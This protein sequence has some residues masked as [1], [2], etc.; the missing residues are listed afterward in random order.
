VKIRVF[1]K[2]KALLHGI[3]VFQ[4]YLLIGASRR[5]KTCWLYQ[6]HRFV[7][8]KNCAGFQAVL[9]ALH[10]NITVDRKLLTVSYHGSFG[11]TGLVARLARSSRCCSGGDCLDHFS[12]EG[13]ENY[14]NFFLRIP[15][16][17][18][19]CIFTACSSSA[20]SWYFGFLVFMRPSRL[21]C[22]WS[23]I[24]RRSWLPARQKPSESQH[25][26]PTWS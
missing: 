22:I 18:N 23:T 8:N 19:V 1:P 17:W 9:R 13:S 16:S 24:R 25:S 10:E 15:P 21:C 11:H 12:S 20:G 5:E 26:P 2:R 4:A 6:L 14:F 7:A 3:G